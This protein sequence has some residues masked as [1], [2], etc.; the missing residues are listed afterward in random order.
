MMKRYDIVGQW[1]EQENEL[2]DWVAHHEADARIAE[3]TKE[4]ASVTDKY[5]N[6]QIDYRA[7]TSEMIAAEMK[8]SELA[9]AKEEG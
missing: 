8:V 5:K 7:G 1:E 2:G 6:C 3:L 9:A 4:L